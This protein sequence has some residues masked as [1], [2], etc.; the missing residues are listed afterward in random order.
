M[1]KWGNIAKS[2]TNKLKPAKNLSQWQLVKRS[3]VKHRL[4]V[5][6]LFLLKIMYLVVLFAEFFAP[7]TSQWRDLDYAYCPP[8]IPR[9]SISKGLH[10]Y[11]MERY[12]D[13]ITFKKS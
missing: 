8:Q 9:Y 13:P 6:S 12:I 1:K 11:A 3:F 10:V 4:A 5:W 2:G 7:H